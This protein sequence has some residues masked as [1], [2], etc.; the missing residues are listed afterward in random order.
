MFIPS[1]MMTQHPDNAREYVSVQQE[2][3]EA[4]EALKKQDE[5][6]L[7]IEE[8]MVDFEGK[9]TPYHQPLQIALELF[10]N[11]VVPGKDALITPRLASAGK[12]SMFR[13][14]MCI[15]AVIETNITMFEKTGYQAIREVII[16]MVETAQDIIDVYHRVKSVVEL[17]NKNFSIKF[18]ENSINVIPLLEDASTLIDVDKLLDEYVDEL[19]KEGYTPKYIRYMIG[20][21]DSALSYG[22][23]SSVLSVAL[24]LYKSQ[25]WSLEKGIEIYPIMGC[26]TLPFRGQ[27][28][29][30]NREK[31]LKTYAGVRTSTIQSAL[32]YDHELD[33][34]K[35]L[36][37]YI[38][39]NASKNE[40]EDYSKEDIE[41]MLNMMG[42]ATKHYLKAFTNII[43]VV[44]NV[45]LL[46]PKNRDRLAAS[47]KGL[48][49]SRE[50]VDL[51]KFAEFVV[52]QN[53]KNE[54]LDIDTN[55][56]V[57]IPRAITFTAAMYTIGMPPELIGTGKALYE[58]KEKYGQ[59]GIEKLLR[60]YP[61]LKEDML[62]AL[63]YANPAILKRFVSDEIRQDFKN[64]IALINELL[65]LNFDLDENIENE[66]YHTLL[67]TAR[68]M[69]LH[70]LGKEDQIL[71]NNSQEYS[72]V[73]ELITKMGVIRGG[74]G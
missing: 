1:T 38:N 67:K 46:L 43:E 73:K 5:E 24:S 53:I 48:S 7:G 69:I 51:K 13:Q 10:S 60:F 70:I 33:K 65:E 8:V 68:P 45:A 54:L 41:L 64:E 37:G 55:V 71:D 66:Y 35:D 17:G 72:I 32:R 52:D 34:A 28:T 19:N 47:R 63:K 15:M 40:R 2:P 36:I 20:R 11:G 4:V 44:S 22:I 3:L 26:G 49:Y 25:K 74:L 14:L 50:F 21:S 39:E 27:L 9:L 57:S 31:F 59:E 6:G 16:P 42:I 56:N 29:N 30:E 18:D 23:I 61:Q 58:I 12:E 62:F